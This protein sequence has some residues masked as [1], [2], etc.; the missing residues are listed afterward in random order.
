MGLIICYSCGRQRNLP[1]V[2]RQKMVCSNCGAHG[3]RL[4]NRI[5]SR[6]RL[7]GIDEADIEGI[8]LHEARARTLSGL[9][10]IAEQKGYKPGY[11]S[12]KFKSIY[13]SWPNG[14]SG[15]PPGSPTQGLLKW[16]AYGN[17]AYKK[18]MRAI[19]AQEVKPKEA[20][21]TSPLMSAEDWNVAL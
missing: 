16:I 12:A 1:K 15:V 14:E 21:P 9:K 17:V 8:D 13:G 2:K 6:M 7:D 18:K 10:W 19:E 3:P 5:T 11:A 4:I 20:E